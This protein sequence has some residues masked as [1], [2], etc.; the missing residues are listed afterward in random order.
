[1]GRAASHLNP[2]KRDGD[3]HHQHGEVKASHDGEEGVEP[4]QMA[5]P[6]AGEDKPKSGEQEQQQQDKGEGSSQDEQEG[7]QASGGEDTREHKEDW[8]GGLFA[9]PRRQLMSEARGTLM[10]VASKGAEFLDKH[11]GKGGKF[12][13]AKFMLTGKG[14]VRQKITW[15][16]TGLAK[17]AKIA[18]VLGATS[19]AA[20]ERMKGKKPGLAEAIEKSYG[21]AVLPNVAKAGAVLGGSYGKGELFERGGKLSGYIA[22]AKLTIGVQLGGETFDELILFENKNAFDDFKKGKIKFSADASVAIANI[23]AAISNDPSGGMNVN[24][25]SDGGFILEAAIGGQKFVYRPKVL[26]G[27]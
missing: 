6:A 24:L 14:K 19:K 8:E 25:K 22:L 26:G 5:R 10:T 27:A 18:P 13:M 1:V 2:L 4:A 12:A 15:A 7:Q 20:L 9:W 16:V 11:G 23:G 21:Y 3:G 17:E